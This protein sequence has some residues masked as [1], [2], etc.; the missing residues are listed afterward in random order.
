MNLDSEI[1]PK[2]ET[3]IGKND[4]LEIYNLKNKMKGEV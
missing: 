4:N 3:I 1:F 2:K